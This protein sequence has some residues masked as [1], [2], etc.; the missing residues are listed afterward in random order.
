[1]AM[2]NKSEGK[3]AHKIPQNPQIWCSIEAM[4]GGQI[5]LLL[6]RT[7]FPRPGE[8]TQID[9]STKPAVASHG[10]GWWNS[11]GFIIFAWRWGRWGNSL[12]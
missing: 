4:F 6:L 10:T 1:M 2:L 7:G 8:T 3:K 11:C 9:R 12:L 5:Q